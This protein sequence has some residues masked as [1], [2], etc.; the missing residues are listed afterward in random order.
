MMTATTQQ[1]HDFYSRLEPGSLVP[2]WERMKGLV[3]R[4]PN[5]RTLAHIWRF[6]EVR[7]LLL[8]AGTLLTAQ[9]AERRVLVFE[10]PA[11]PG[12]SRINSTLYAGMQLILPG[13]TAPAHRHA[14][15]A[16]RFI[17]ES[18][19]G[20]TT[21]AGERADMKHGDL[22][23]TPSGTW[24]D[25]GHD[26]QGPCI[27][28]DALDVPLVNIFECGFSEELDDNQQ[29]IT[30]KNGHSLSEFGSGMLPM[31]P[32]SPFGKTSPVFSY[33]YDRARAALMALKAS[34]PADAFQGYSLR[35][36]NPLDGG[37]V[38]PMIAAWLSYLP[39]GFETSPYR[40]TDNQ[41][42][43]VAEGLVTVK[44]RGEVYKLGKN[45]VMALPGWCWR[46]IKAEEDAVLFF[47]SDRSAQEKL[48]IWREQRRNKTEADR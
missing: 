47:F 39:T 10:N 37:W 34:V 41:A 31:D 28:V 38:M 6:E 40:A 21:V 1:R 23:I 11:F 9:E 17:L 12:T 19:G 42:V 16:L 5:N 32:I 15:G 2:L 13:E 25:H 30:R 43:I 44:L 45:D 8:E 36:A 46:T 35:Y 20:Y 26:G 24:H 18:D 29:Q 48:G 14:A 27:W 4:E 33:P 7:P 3:P 22:V